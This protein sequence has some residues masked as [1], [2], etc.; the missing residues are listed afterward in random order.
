MFDDTGRAWGIH[1][2]QSRKA[3]ERAQGDDKSGLVCIGWTRLGDLS[4]H[5]T[6]DKLKTHYA[7]R[8]PEKSMAHIRTSAGQV[9]RFAHEMQ[10][11]DPIVY[12]IKGSR[13][14]LIGRIAGPYEYRDDPE[15]QAADAANVRKVEWLQRVPRVAFSQP[16]LNSFG[17]FLSVFQVDEH[18]PEI[19]EV[20]AGRES[21]PEEAVSPADDA[22]GSSDAVDE[23][24]EDARDAV[25]EA[26]QAT[27]DYLLRKWT[28]SKQDFEEVVAGVFRALGYTATVTQATHDLGVDIVAHQDPLGVS[29][30]VLKIEVKSGTSSIGAPAVKQLRG[31][32][33]QG[34]KGVLVSLGGFSTD[35]RHTDQNDANLVLIDADRFVDLFLSSYEKLP[36]DL[37]HRFP[38]QPV[39]VVAS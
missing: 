22:A 33:N 35:A 10:V 30:V 37:R 6:I 38:L 8:M 31:V 36:A 4:P 5:D 7:E 26:T 23:A 17:A 2:S 29:G 12:P 24:E 25:E 11:D 39:Y 18:L 3:A 16:A 1:I 20:L 21:P 9:F 34:E 28:R 15:L 13:D 32:L 14:V 27:K 19:N